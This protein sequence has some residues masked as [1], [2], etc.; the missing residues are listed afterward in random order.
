MEL[1][2]QSFLYFG[3]GSNLLTE[4]IHINNPSAKFV[5]IASL[6]NYKLTFGY[7]SKRWGGAAA[8][9]VPA[10][11]FKV[12]GVL[13][14]LSMEHLASLDKQE[15][16]PKIYERIKVSVVSPEL[17]RYNAWSYNL[18][19]GLDAD[20]IP[21]AVYQKVILK[22]AMEHGLPDE[23]LKFLCEIKNNGFEG[24]DESPM[25]LASLV[26]TGDEKC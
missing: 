2:A 25:K 20:P 26:E 19:T 22:G 24:N 4:R 8:T 15:G 21:S 3:Y 6:D 13:W 1:G 11:G 10:I 9:I 5:S 18:V 12:W 23:Y 16:V 7:K 17:Q 14:A